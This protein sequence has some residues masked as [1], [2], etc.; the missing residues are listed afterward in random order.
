[1]NSIGWVVLGAVLCLGIIT[2]TIVLLIFGLRRGTQAVSEKLQEQEAQ[3]TAPS[4]SVNA[5]TRW[6]QGDL[7]AAPE[8][9]KSEVVLEPCPACGG[10]NP[11]G[12][13]VCGFCGRNL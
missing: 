12:A 5:N 9:P 13:G 4:E 10:E 8:L 3:E 6:A 1:M 7:K 11:R 2:L